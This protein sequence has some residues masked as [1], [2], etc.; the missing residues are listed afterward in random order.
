MNK[1]RRMVALQ[2]RALAAA[3]AL[4]LALDLHGCGDSGGDFSE[5]SWSSWSADVRLGLAWLRSQVPVP[6]WAWGLRGGCLLAAESTRGADGPDH[7]LL[8]Q[9]PPSGRQLLQ[10]FLRLRAAVEAMDGG[11]KGV[12]EGLRQ[13]LGAGRAVEVAGYALGPGLSSGL[14]AA[15]MAPETR[16]G[17]VCIV[18]RAISE[19]DLEP[20]PGTQKLAAQWREAGWTVQAHA[21]PGPAFWQTTEIET[22]P[23][24]IDLTQQLLRQ[25]G[26]LA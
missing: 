24:W 16:S 26:A 23:A 12:V 3:G 13:E 14:D 21:A 5:A 8:W 17:C 1:S 19:Q 6:I 11:G 2:S 18:E 15:T 7:V 25:A 10:Q 9:P 22:A 20:T 4:V